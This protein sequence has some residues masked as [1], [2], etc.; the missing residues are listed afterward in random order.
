MVTE[1]GT[2]AIATFA[3]GTALFLGFFSLVAACDG[4]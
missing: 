1:Y 2:M 4:L 3:V